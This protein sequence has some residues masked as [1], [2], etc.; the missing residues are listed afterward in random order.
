[1]H[2]WPP[3]LL[4]T[5]ADFGKWKLARQESDSMKIDQILQFI[6]PASK[7]VYVE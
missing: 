4:F 5:F 1:M 6:S 7:M 3:T 2:S